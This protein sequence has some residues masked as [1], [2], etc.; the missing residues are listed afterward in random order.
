MTGAPSGP[1]HHQTNNELRAKPRKTARRE[2]R[3]LRAP[4]VDAARPADPEPRVSC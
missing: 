3:P 2:G 4:A 1:A